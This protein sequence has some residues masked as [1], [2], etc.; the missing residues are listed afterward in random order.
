MSQILAEY[1]KMLKICQAEAKQDDFKKAGEGPR[2]IMNSF[3][4]ERTRNMIPEVIGAG[5]LN[6]VTR[7][8]LVNSVYFNGI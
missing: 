4:A 1:Q 3:V 8:V 7:L 2:R 5:G 6:S